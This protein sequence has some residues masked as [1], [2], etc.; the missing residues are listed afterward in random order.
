M[1]FGPTAYD[2]PMKALTRLRQVTTMS[3][4]AEFQSLYNRLRGLS[5]RNKLSC[6]LNGLNDEIRLPVRILIPT[7]LNAQFKKSMRGAA[8]RL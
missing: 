5:E 3:Y 1:R 7:T 2:D 4:K 8:E 6:F